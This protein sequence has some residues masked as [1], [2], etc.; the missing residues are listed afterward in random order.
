ME[1][2]LLSYSYT[3]NQLTKREEKHLER[4]S[5]HTHTPTHTQTH[6]H[7][8]AFTLVASHR[9]NSTWLDVVSDD[10]YML[11]SVRTCV[12]VPEADDVAEFM[13]H[14]AE[15]IAVLSDGDGLRAAASPPHVGAA[16]AGGAT[17]FSYEHLQN[18]LGGCL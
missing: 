2:I 7:A 12:F 4:L 11:V 17:L 13:H 18:K 15:L 9:S 3:E 1:V 16:P 5:A 10:A 6:K 8:H 14:N